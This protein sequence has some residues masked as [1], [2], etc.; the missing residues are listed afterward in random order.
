MGSPPTIWLLTVFFSVVSRTLRTALRRYRA[1]G[2]VGD[3]GGGT[4]SVSERVA[5][6]VTVS[7]GPRRT[8][9]GLSS[10]VTG[11]GRI[12]AVIDMIA[13]EESTVCSVSTSV[14]ALSAETEAP[15]PTD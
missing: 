13:T 4:T 1:G 3:V 14:L 8:S 9:G 2:S 5:T 12:S 15:L 11:L 10:A 6:I 7:A